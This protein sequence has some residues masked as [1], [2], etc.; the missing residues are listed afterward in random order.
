MTQEHNHLRPDFP[1]GAG[2]GK[3][4]YSICYL[5]REPID[6]YEDAAF[7]QGVYHR[8]C[9]APPEEPA[10]DADGACPTCGHTP[11]KPASN[12]VRPRDGSAPRVGMQTAMQMPGVSVPH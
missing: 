7:I 5:C 1:A 10:P 2:K 12:A 6:T 3:T 4:M 8:A 9:A 11:P